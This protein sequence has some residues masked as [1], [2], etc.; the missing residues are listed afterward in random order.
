M[1][2]AGYSVS[3][4]C[5]CLSQ[6]AINSAV[7]VPVTAGYGLQ[8]KAHDNANCKSLWSSCSMGLW[9]CQTW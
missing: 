7:A 6:S 4:K 5:M 8:C 9:C 1:A 2:M 3:T